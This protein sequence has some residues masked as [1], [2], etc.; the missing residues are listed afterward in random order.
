[1]PAAD[2]NGAV[3]PAY[4]LA[5]IVDDVEVLAVNR[6]AAVGPDDAA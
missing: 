2:G 4:A 5:A 1:M 3:H 6:G